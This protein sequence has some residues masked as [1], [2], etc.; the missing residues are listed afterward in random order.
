MADYR[1]FRRRSRRR[2]MRRRL[3]AVS[4]LAAVALLACGLAWATFTGRLGG[5]EAAQSTAAAQSAAQPT[6]QPTPT[7]APSSSAGFAL[8]AN[9]DANWNQSGYTVR[10]LDKTVQKQDDGTTAMD[11]RL[12][13]Q[14][15]SGV[16][17][18]SYFN[19]ATFLGDSLTQGLEIYSEGLPNAHYCAYKGAGPSAVVNNTEVKNTKGE[20]QIPMDALVASAPDRIYVLMGTN[21]LVRTGNDAS[22]LAYYAQ[23]IDMIQAALPTTHI[24][25]Q[26]IT[27]VRPEVTADKPGLY[28]ARLM[29][30]NDELAA[31]ALQKN[32]SFL[33]LWEVLADDNGDL[34][35]DYAQPDGIHVK[36]EGYTV[37]VNY[38]RTHTVYTPGVS[39]E[40]GTSYYIEQ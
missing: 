40:A 27:P 23:M 8:T 16:V 22:F 19:T 10:V 6:A 35:A 1:E 34:I 31:L 21:V 38:L 36:P 7:A 2:R 32:C 28:K 17:D 13:S 24:Y 11:F 30:I 5:R 18:L 3:A 33:D 15:S 9:A 26:S 20:A 29:A 39:Y 4:S 14:D 37:W 25:I 12:A